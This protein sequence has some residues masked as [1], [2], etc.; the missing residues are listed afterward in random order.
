[1]KNRIKIKPLVVGWVPSK[2]KLDLMYEGREK[3][4]PGYWLYQLQLKYRGT[5]RLDKLGRLIGWIFGILYSN[6]RVGV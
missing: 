1:M 3:E 6:K 5:R 2:S 4:L